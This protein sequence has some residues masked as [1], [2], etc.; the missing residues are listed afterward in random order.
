MKK[1]IE[2]YDNSVKDK[3]YLKHGSTF[4]NSGYVDYLDENYQ[5]Q[6]E[7]ASKE[8]V[9]NSDHPMIKALMW[10]QQRQVEK[11]DV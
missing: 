9:D 11:Q 6:P 10:Q 1:A 7:Q 2:R 3:E 4:F 8:K 5:E